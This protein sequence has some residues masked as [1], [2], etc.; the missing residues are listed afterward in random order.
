MKDYNELP[1][2]LVLEI[3][4]EKFKLHSYK[5]RDTIFT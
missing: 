2:F 4:V 3:I 1:Q 5:K